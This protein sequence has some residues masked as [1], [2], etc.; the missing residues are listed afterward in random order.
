MRAGFLVVGLVVIVVSVGVF[1]SSYSYLLSN[2]A[3]IFANLP[4]GLSDSVRQR[5]VMDKYICLISGFV[6]IIGLA[7]T[8]FGLAAEQKKKVTKI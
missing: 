5:I 1:W 7:I 3:P 2:H 4:K 8:A 6:A